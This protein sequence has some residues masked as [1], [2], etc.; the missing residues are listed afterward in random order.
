MKSGAAMLLGDIHKSSF[1]ISVLAKAFFTIQEATYLEN[2][3]KVAATIS[4]GMGRSRCVKKI[5]E[6]QVEDGRNDY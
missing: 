4:D 6:K 2:M 1:E 3:A 5:E